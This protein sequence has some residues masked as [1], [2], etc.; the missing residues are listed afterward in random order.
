MQADAPVAGRSVLLV[1]DLMA[2]GGTMDSGKIVIG[3]LRGAGS[4]LCCN[5]RIGRAWWA[6]GA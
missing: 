5:Y 6:C 1:D 2:T 4:C 3:G